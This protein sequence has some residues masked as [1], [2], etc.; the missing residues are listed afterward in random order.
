MTIND[1]DAPSGS[2]GTIRFTSAS[3]TPTVS[4]GAASI[5]LT[6]ERTGGSTGLVSAAVNTADGSATAGADYR[7]DHQRRR[8]LDQ[9]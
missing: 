4:E 7:G 3:A 8:H 2:P 1:D 5:T 9:R 6:A